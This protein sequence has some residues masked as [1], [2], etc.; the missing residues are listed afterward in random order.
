MRR[1]VDRGQNLVELAIVMPL[2]LL[3]LMGVIDLGRAFHA[4]IVEENAAREAA[5]YGASHPSQLTGA[6]SAEER[7]ITEATN[8]GISPVTVNVQKLSGSD[9]TIQATVSYQFSLLSGFLGIGP[10]NLSGT[11]EMT[12]L[13]LL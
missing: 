8:A 6:D 4:Y 10:L 9:T 1:R 2:L 3:I 13:A 7:A 12:V 11:A 5:R